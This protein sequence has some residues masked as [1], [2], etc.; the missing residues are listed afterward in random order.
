VADQS[1]HPGNP[2]PPFARRRS[3]PAARVR[4]A[5]VKTAVGGSGGESRFAHRPSPSSDGPNGRRPPAA[6]DGHKTEAANS[7]R[8]VPAHLSSA[9]LLMK[10]SGGAHPDQN[11]ASCRAP[12][13]SP[14]RQS[15]HRVTLRRDPGRYDEGQPRG[16]ICCRHL[17]GGRCQHR[18]FAV[19]LEESCHLTYR[20]TQ[21]RRVSPP[22]GYG[23][24]G[25]TR[26]A[27]SAD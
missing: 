8:N 7:S 18:Q 2:R 21:P 24:A 12:S 1:R 22:G 27:G 26:A 5:T 15:R 19:A 17:R 4:C 9:I 16:S 25:P 11:L 10:G 3:A 20:S 14:P 13:S 23:A 6:K